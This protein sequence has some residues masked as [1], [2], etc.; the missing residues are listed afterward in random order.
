MCEDDEL[1]ALLRE[2]NRAQFPEGYVPFS[3][4]IEVCACEGLE[5]IREILLHADAAA[6]TYLTPDPARL[7]KMATIEPWQEMNRHYIQVMYEAC[8]SGH[9]LPCASDGENIDC[10]VCVVC[11]NHDPGDPTGIIPVQLDPVNWPP[12][13]YR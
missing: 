2:A 8:E 3:E 10:F 12:S 7:E 11:A 9:I 13:V 5:T 4:Y 1:E 6:A